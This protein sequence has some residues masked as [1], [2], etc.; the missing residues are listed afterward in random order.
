MFCALT[1]HQ[2]P[3]RML[4]KITSYNPRNFWKINIFY[5]GS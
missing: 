3:N 1:A 5:F 4:S 2:T